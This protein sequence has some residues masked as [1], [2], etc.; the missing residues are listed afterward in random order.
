[1]V[2]P[3]GGQVYEVQLPPAPY[4]NLN[5]EEARYFVREEAATVLQCLT[6]E[7]GQLGLIAGPVHQTVGACFPRTP[8][9]LNSLRSSAHV[10]CSPGG[11]GAAT[12]ACRRWPGWCAG[13]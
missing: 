13:H 8:V 3:F 1:M 2:F 4:S 5:C 11:A 9:T 6:C 10:P 7:R 12:G